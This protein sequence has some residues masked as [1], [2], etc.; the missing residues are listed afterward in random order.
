MLKLLY[1]KDSNSTLTG[2]ITIRGTYL[3]ISAQTEENGG[4]SG[5]DSIEALLPYHSYVFA[6]LKNSKVK[7][8][9]TI[10]RTDYKFLDM[11]RLGVAIRMDYADMVQLYSEADI[12]QIDTGMINGTTR[13]IVIR[14]F[15]GQS[16]SF[17]LDAD[18]DHE[19]G[20]FSSVSLPQESHP[21]TTLWDSYSITIGDQ[22]FQA[23]RYGNLTKG[24]AMT[25]ISYGDP[26]EIHIKK[27]KGAFESLLTRDIDNDDV[28]LECTC[29]LLNAR[30]IRLVKGEGAVKLYPF[31]YSGPFK[32][33]LGRKWYEVW[34]EY[35]LIL[36][37]KS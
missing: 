30:R 29:G 28:L 36:G 37:A 34:N 13:D 33:K 32:L 9:R 7:V 5:E 10:H 25:P 8:F 31:E 22:E 35:N 18:M 4:L 3:T 21:R 12:L 16:G 24:D 6:R 19:E 17:T 1:N 2:K 11:N 26:I 14:V 23:D 20:T 15:E 27:Y